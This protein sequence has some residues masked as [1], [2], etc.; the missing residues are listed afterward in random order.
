MNIT[1]L[2]PN[3]PF[4]FERLFKLLETLSEYNVRNDSNYSI[5]FYSMRSKPVMMY[6]NYS[7]DYIKKDLLQNWMDEEKYNSTTF[8]IISIEFGYPTV[9]RLLMLDSFFINKNN[10]TTFEERLPDVY[11][12]WD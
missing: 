12:E 11:T 10:R 6:L 7:L 4:T 2:T 1:K 3:K 8:D 9:I 5:E